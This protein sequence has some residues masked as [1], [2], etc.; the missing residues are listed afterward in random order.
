[1]IKLNFYVRKQSG[2]SREEFQSRWRDGHGALWARHAEALG[3]RRYT[4]VYDDPEH[5]VA[6]ALKQGYQVVGA[7]YDGLSVACWSELAVLEEALKTEEGAAAWHA[8]LEDEKEFI[9]HGLSMLSFG[10]DHPVLNPRGKL[11]ADEESDMVRGAYFPKGLPG[12]EL[13]EL[14]RHW[15]AIHGGLTH[16]LS[17][18]SPNIRYFQIHS[19]ENAVATDM[20]A[21]RGMLPSERYFGHAEV[22]ISQ[23]EMDKASENPIRQELF[24]LFVADIEAFCDM[25]TGYFIIGKEKHFVDMPIYTLPLPQPQFTVAQEKTGT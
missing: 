7:A 22:W 3:V 2:M 9:D 5:S 25:D 10:T 24:P 23:A 18:Y 4:Q 17:T 15:I 14:H 8:I 19:V 6:Q 20:R 1:M 13:T 12:I 11:Y 21:A 16:D